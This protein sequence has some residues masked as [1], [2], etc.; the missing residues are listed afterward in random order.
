M[1]VKDG[2]CNAAPSTAKLHGAGLPHAQ[3]SPRPLGNGHRTAQNTV[4]EAV[5]ENGIAYSQARHSRA[6]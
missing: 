3:P 6:Y 4:A 5:V 2:G 1:F